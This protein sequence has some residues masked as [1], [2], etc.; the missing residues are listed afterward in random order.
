MS[1]KYLHAHLNNDL[2]EKNLS[3]RKDIKRMKADIFTW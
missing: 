1:I 2:K 3:S